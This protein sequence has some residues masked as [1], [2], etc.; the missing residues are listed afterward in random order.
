MRYAHKYSQ[1]QKSR[2]LI[3]DFFSLHM[4]ANAIKRERNITPRLS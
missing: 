4:K 1:K 3:G 2:L